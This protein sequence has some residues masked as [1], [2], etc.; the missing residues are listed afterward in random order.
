MAKVNYIKVHPGLGKTEEEKE[1]LKNKAEEINRRV[2]ERIAERVKQ[3]QIK[4]DTNDII[5]TDAEKKK[6]ALEYF[7][8]NY[9]KSKDSEIPAIEVFNKMKEKTQ[10]KILSFKFMQ[11]LREDGKTLEKKDKYYIIGYKRKE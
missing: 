8:N 2:E 4:K 3:G 9:V 7:N 1:E 5:L 10:L 11:Y 6:A